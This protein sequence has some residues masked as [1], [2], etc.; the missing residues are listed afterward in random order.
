MVGLSTVMSLLKVY[1]APL[2]GAVTLFSMVP[3]IVASYRHGLKWGL[4]TGFIY[5]VLQFLLGVGSVSYLAGPASIILC[6]LFDYIVA[7]TVVGFGGMFKSLKIDKNAQIILGTIA[8]CVLRYAA[9]VFVGA[10]VWYEL[11]KSGGWND[12]VQTVG[13]WTYSLVYNMQYMLPETVITVIGAAAVI[14]ILPLV[15]KKLTSTAK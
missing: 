4:C 8:V 15:S 12:Y 2:G 1:E 11:T 5:S 9:H 14:N 6:I 10:V 13:M 7:F 3:I